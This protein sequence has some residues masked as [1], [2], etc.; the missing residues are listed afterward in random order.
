MVTL[1]TTLNHF[2]P[3]LNS[4]LTGL[5]EIPGEGGAGL[6]VRPE[7]HRVLPD[8]HQHHRRAQILHS[9]LSLLT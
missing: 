5:P 3:S 6:V 1:Y 2:S 8:H 9:L 4:C 7:A